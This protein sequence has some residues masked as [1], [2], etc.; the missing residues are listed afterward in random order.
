MEEEKNIIYIPA[1]GNYIE[2]LGHKIEGYSS[3]ESFCK[4]L[5]ELK[6]IKKQYKELKEI[7]EFHKKENGELRERVNHLEEENEELKIIKNGIKTLE[8]NF[9][10]DDTYYVI[11]KKGFLKGEY[12]HLLD[13]YIPV[14]LVEE[15]ILNPMKE[16]HD[17][18]INGFIKR[19]IPQC[20]EDGGIAQELGYFIGKIEELLEKRK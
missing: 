2:I 5:N 11:G 17:K 6:D 18:A 7:E 14:S 15:K 9:A 3:F 19:D 16:E 13:D 1:E 12:K 8:T 10:N 4:E 20:I